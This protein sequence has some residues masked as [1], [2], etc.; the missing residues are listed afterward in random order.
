MTKIIPPSDLICM[1]E[2][3]ESHALRIDL[4][5]ADAQHPENLFKEAIYCEK[6]KMWLHKDMA[7]I[8][9]KASEFARTIGRKLVLK[10][11]LRPVNAQKKMLETDIVK[12]NPHWLVAPRLLSPPGLGG[13][14]R[15]M[16]I[17]L[18]IEDENGNELDFG[19]PFD[20]LPP[21]GA[22]NPA[23]RDYEDLPKEAL[24]NRKYLERIMHESAILT[25]KVILPLPNEWWDFRFT[26]DVYNQYTPL[27]EEDLPFQVTNQK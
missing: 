12:A 2:Y 5:Y 7:E 6:A 16:A 21:K 20:A 22:P 1:D 19:T 14:P 23:A 15:G 17:D 27:S 11:G 4:V 3:Q 10:D 25:G 13:H 26:A 18:T 8:V 9:L 24:K